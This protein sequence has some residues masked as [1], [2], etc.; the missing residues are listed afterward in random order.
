M[1]QNVGNLKHASRSIALNIHLGILAIS[2]MMLQKVE[3]S[4]IW[5]QFLTFLAQVSKESN[6]AEL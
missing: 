6:K 3:K 2:P 1:E 4:T 5:S